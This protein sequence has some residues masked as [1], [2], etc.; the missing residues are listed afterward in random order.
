[1]AV[2]YHSWNEKI[3]KY[4]FNEGSKDTDIIFYVNE[5]VIND[6]GLELNIENPVESFCKCVLDKICQP[7]TYQQN[8]YIL[9]LKNNI[10]NEINEDNIPLQTAFI[11]FMIYAANILATDETDDDSEGE[12]QKYSRGYWNKIRYLIRNIKQVCPSNKP[13]M[14]NNNYDRCLEFFD[15]FE[16]FVNYNNFNF[17]FINIYERKQRRDLIGKPISHA[18]ITEKDRIQLYNNHFFKYYEQEQDVLATDDLNLILQDEEFSKGFKKIAKKNRLNHFLKEQIKQL[19]KNYDGSKI[20]IIETKTT[21]GYS[22]REVKKRTFFKLSYDNEKF[23]EEIPCK[24]YKENELIIDN[25]KY[26]R[27]VNVF[28]R[29]LS[30]AEIDLSQTYLSEEKK[31][32][33]KKE[34][35][36]LVQNNDGNGY[37]EK[38]DSVKINDDILLIS[39][40][41]F[42]NTNKEE[43]TNIFGS[44]YTTERLNES[45]FVIKEKVIQSSPLLNIKDEG[46]IIFKK[47]L[48]NGGK[49]EY[50]DGA[51]PVLEIKKENQEIY[52]SIDEKPRMYLKEI[53]LNKENIPTLTKNIGKHK[54][55][56]WTKLKSLKTTKKGNIKE[57]EEIVH[58]GTKNYEIKDEFIEE[59]QSDFEFIEPK[60]LY[61]IIDT[62]LQVITTTDFSDDKMNIINGCYIEN[63]NIQENQNI[64]DT[65]KKEYIE[66]II[67][68]I[69]KKF[70][71]NECNWNEVY[72]RFIIN[73]ENYS[74]TMSEPDQEKYIKQIV[75]KN[76]TNKY[77][78][79]LGQ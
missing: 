52:F 69:C 47:G 64:V 62:N 28:Y 21:K 25:I 26:S 5:N 2:D 24:N 61:K 22:K 32:S 76:I 3:Y 49:N 34:Y 60:I 75:L 78:Q 31:I 13:L 14:D 53:P 15:S 73:L 65:D 17:K 54:I 4:F 58:L 9:K 40:E 18:I 77:L 51:E 7:R 66:M 48:R 16:K 59:Q 63:L 38:Q 8:E 79:K 44:K 12:E 1:M 36:I 55:E 19:Y 6:I 20:E 72:N 23:F 42:F 68:A 39:S 29:S 50:L 10:S 71:R 41:D 43:L 33:T 37:I 57:K 35:R 70:I 11:A 74:E 45:L 67:K 27:D 30:E 46:K 56:V